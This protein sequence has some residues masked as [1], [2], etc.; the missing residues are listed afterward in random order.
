ME[1]TEKKSGIIT[2]LLSRT[3]G[4]RAMWMLAALSRILNQLLT[5][6]IIVL[7]GHIL[8]EGGPFVA[9]WWVAT[10]SLVKA[11][12]RYSEHY[13]GHWVA[14]TMLTRLRTE[15]YNALVDQAPAVVKNVD[16]AEISEKATRDI[17]RIEVFFA[18]TIPPALSA[19]VVP[20][21]SILWAGFFLGWPYA[22]IILMA[23][24]VMVAV[25]AF[26]RRLTWK[27]ARIQAGHNAAISTHVGD[28]IQGLRE[29]RAFGA[30]GLRLNQWKSLEKRAAKVRRP[31]HVLAAFRAAILI[32]AELLTMGILLSQGQLTSAVLATLTWVAL[33]APL[34]GIDDFVDGLD[35]ALASA[36]RIRSGIEAAPVVS[37]T[38]TRSL[39]YTVSSPIIALEA[40]DF[41]YGNRAF[42]LRE[43][44]LAFERGSWNYIVGVSG[45]GK[46]TLAAV[47]ARGWDPQLG[48]VTFSSVPLPQIPLTELRQRVSLVVQRPVL[49][50]ATLAENL[51]LCQPQLSRTAMWELLKC[52]GLD[53]W[54]HE[55][56]DGLDEVITT[57]GKN[58]SGGQIQRLAIARALAGKPDVLILD[59]AM[60]QLDEVTACNAREQIRDRFPHITV[61]E[62]SHQVDRI[63]GDERIVVMDGGRVVEDGIKSELQSDSHSYTSRLHQRA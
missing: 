22:G 4:V 16:T 34:R 58:M 29:I 28:S 38:G 32:I 19:V 57:D 63:S 25:P 62:I 52:V 8:L 13:C 56:P 23:S 43:I 61:I 2:W 36:Q 31:I 33:W 59:E 21:L 41:F 44:T 14:F 12:F 20:L 6:G 54:A 5:V 30:E 46:S 9:L 48:Q 51:R 26:G 40:V 47:I 11:L 50:E 27:K 35:E 45:S 17:D 55:L 1:S 10:L 53:G 24:A 18:H 37:D 42:E 60:S 15:Y 7:I 49:L 39:D 3:Q